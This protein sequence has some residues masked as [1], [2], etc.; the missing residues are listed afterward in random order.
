[1]QAGFETL[2]TWDDKLPAPQTDV[3][4]TVRRRI[5]AQMEALL[6]PEL[7]KHDPKLAMKFEHIREEID[8][9]FDKWTPR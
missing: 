9:M 7:R 2:A 6:V 8:R 1:M 3:E 5:K 4:R